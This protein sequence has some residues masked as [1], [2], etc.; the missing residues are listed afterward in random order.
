MVT[1]ISVTAYF[2]FEICDTLWRDAVHVFLKSP[3]KSKKQMEQYKE[4]GG[5]RPHIDESIGSRYTDQGN[6]RLKCPQLY[7]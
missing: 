2:T 7:Y 5:Q 6:E 1:N 3:T 4:S